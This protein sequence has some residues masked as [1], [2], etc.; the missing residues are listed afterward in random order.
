[1]SNLARRAFFE[2]AY[3]ASRLDAPESYG[4]EPLNVDRDRLGKSWQTL[5]PDKTHSKAT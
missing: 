1:M 3:P 5:H 4:L 2:V